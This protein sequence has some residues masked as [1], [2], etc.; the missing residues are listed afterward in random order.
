MKRR[1]KYLSAKYGRRLGVDENAGPSQAGAAGWE[2][3]HIQGEKKSTEENDYTTSTTPRGQAKEEGDRLKVWKD[4]LIWSY[5]PGRSGP[6]NRPRG[7]RTTIG[8]SPRPAL[9]TA[10]HKSW[11]AERASAAGVDEEAGEIIEHAPANRS[12]RRF[13]SKRSELLFSE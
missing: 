8:R 12:R 2:L 11:A 1:T 10:A 13:E 6:R 4:E 7:R 9:A 5:D 3:Q